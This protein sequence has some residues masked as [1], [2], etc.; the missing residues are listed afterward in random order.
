MFELMRKLVDAYAHAL[1]EQG[2][3]DDRYA[4]LLAQKPDAREADCR[5]RRAATATKGKKAS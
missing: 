4:E 5:D 1:I 3:Y 2:E